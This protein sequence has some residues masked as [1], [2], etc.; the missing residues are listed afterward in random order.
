MISK[1][2]TA[3]AAASNVAI[4]SGAISE[5]ENALELV[6]DHIF[7]LSSRHAQQERRRTIEP[8]DIQYAAKQFKA[9]QK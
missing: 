5:L 6:L 2:A 9:I 7:A 8:A 4:E 3:Q 1:I